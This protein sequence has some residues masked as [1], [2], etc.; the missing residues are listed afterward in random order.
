MNMHEPPLTIFDQDLIDRYEREF[1]D[2]RKVDYP[3]IDAFEKEQG[4]QFGKD[5]LQ[6]AARIL[7]CPVKRHPACW[8]H[9]RVIY[10][11]ARWRIAAWARAP[12]L[13]KPMTFL[14][15]GTAKGF[16]AL[17]MQ[18][19]ID[20]SGSDLDWFQVV[21][22]DVIDPNARVPRNSIAERDGP[23]TLHEML[24]PWQDVARRITFLRSTGVAWLKDRDEQRVHFAFVDGKHTFAAVSEEL[25]LLAKNQRGGEDVIVLD[26][27]Q[28]EGVRKAL[29]GF[30]HAYQ[31]RIIEAIPAAE[32]DRNHAPRAYAVAMRR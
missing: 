8:Q 29:E 25:G 7:A 13:R 23:K 21:S 4:F 14:D 31:W 12:G 2:E 18:Y 19:A 5:R 3:A 20:N 15:I 10:T 6:A 24:V 26:D 28:I 11:T 17:M 16:S 1:E 22:V 30:R 9:G 32:Q 27:V